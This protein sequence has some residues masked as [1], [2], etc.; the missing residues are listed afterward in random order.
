MTVPMNDHCSPRSVDSQHLEQKKIKQNLA[1]NILH[2][3]IFFNDIVI[4]KQSVI[5]E[6][7]CLAYQKQDTIL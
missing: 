4:S 3:V 6:N 2:E 1:I 5:Y 7:N